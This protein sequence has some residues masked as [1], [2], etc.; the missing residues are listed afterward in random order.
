MSIDFKLLNLETIRFIFLIHK[1][2]LIFSI[3]LL[4]KNFEKLSFSPLTL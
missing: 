2:T 4:T 1:F 3:I